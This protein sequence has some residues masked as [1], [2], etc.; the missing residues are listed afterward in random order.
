MAA[1]LGFSLPYDPFL[2]IFESHQISSLSLGHVL[3]DPL[4]TFFSTSEKFLRS[5]SLLKRELARRGGRR[6]EGRRGRNARSPGF[7]PEN[8]GRIARST[9]K[10]KKKKKNTRNDRNKR[11]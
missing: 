5:S 1:A 8:P 3:I 10:K 4:C 2:E 6:E 11:G 9:T 7:H